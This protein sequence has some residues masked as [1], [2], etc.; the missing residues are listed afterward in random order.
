MSSSSGRQLVEPKTETKHTKRYDIA[1]RAF[2]RARSDK[3]TKITLGNRSKKPIPDY[4]NPTPRQDLSAAQKWLTAVAS[5]GL[6][7][8]RDL[9]QVEFPASDITVI[10]PH[11]AKPYKR[12]AKDRGRV[13]AL[14]KLPMSPLATYVS[15]AMIDRIKESPYYVHDKD[16][17]VLECDQHLT[18]AAN[19]R[20]IYANI[21][22]FLR[23][24]GQEIVYRETMGD[25]SN[26]Q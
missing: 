24:V 26:L 21:S 13:K 16:A 12:T 4:H 25:I 8:P 15:P 11:H 7:I 5:A 18:R 9:P 3:L 22:C 1:S 17:V 10:P 2:W 20:R 19:E 14:L 6:V 23:N